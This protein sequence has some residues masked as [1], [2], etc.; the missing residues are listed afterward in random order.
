MRYH[1]EDQTAVVADVLSAIQGVEHVVHHRLFAECPKGLSFVG[2]AR[3]SRVCLLNLYL[4]R[5]G[6]RSLRSLWV[7]V[8]KILEAALKFV[9]TMLSVFGTFLRHAKGFG[10]TRQF[11]RVRKMRAGHEM[12]LLRFFFAIQMPARA[13]RVARTQTIASTGAARR[14]VS[15]H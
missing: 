10:I 9:R 13:R 11:T 5:Y 8:F 15:N 1:G 12:F 3:N 4:A 7:F 14:Q 2:F 6:D